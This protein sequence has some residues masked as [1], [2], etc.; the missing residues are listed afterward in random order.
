MPLLENK[1]EKR[2]WK[3]SVSEAR[4]Y[5]SKPKSSEASCA[6]GRCR[7]LP[8]KAHPA[9]RGK[10]DDGKRRKEYHGTDDLGKERSIGPTVSGAERDEA[11]NAYEPRI[12]GGMNNSGNRG[13][14][15]ASERRRGQA[16]FA[17]RKRRFVVRTLSKD[18]PR[19]LKRRSEEAVES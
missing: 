6:E 16:S 18:P 5:V 8:G 14:S 11:L 2:F 19:S 12:R 13:S 15:S 7:K 1:K 17:A 10:T 3:K 4:G 9:G